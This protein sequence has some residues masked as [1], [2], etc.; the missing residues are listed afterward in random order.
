MVITSKIKSQISFYYVAP[1]LWNKPPTSLQ[2]CSIINPSKDALPPHK[3]PLVS[4]ILFPRL[5]THLFAISCHINLLYNPSHHRT[6]YPDLDFSSVSVAMA[7][8]IHLARLAN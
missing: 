7:P 5:K 8:R 1:K 6:D 2:S 3:P 4:H